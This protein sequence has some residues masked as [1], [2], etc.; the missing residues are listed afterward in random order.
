MLI[1]ILFYLNFKFISDTKTYYRTHTKFETL[2]SLYLYIFILTYKY[3]NLRSQ[4]VVH[5]ETKKRNTNI[6]IFRD[7]IKPC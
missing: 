1:T 4:F 5:Q 6:M 2:I 7:T 3:P